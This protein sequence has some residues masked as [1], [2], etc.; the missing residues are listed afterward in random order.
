M[1]SEFLIA[2]SDF[3]LIDGLKNSV[4]IYTLYLDAKPNSICDNL[5][6]DSPTL[7]VCLVE[8]NKELLFKRRPKVIQGPIRISC[9]TTLNY[10]GNYHI[11]STQR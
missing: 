4:F 2:F 3:K 10:R 11:W 7:G 1:F 9:D 5:F 8:T 6:L